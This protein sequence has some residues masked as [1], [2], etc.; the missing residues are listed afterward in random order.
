[1]SAVMQG[2]AN[3]EI[4][5]QQNTI[6]SQRAFNEQLFNQQY[7]Q[8]MVNRSE[9]SDMFRKLGERQ[10]LERKRDNATSSVM[11]ESVEAGI[12]RDNARGKQYAD[13]TAGIAA[14]AGIY[15]DGLLN[16]WQNY[17]NQYY[18]QLI[19]M[20]DKLAG[21]SANTANQWSKA[22]MG[23]YDI[24]GNFGGDAIDYWKNKG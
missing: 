20:S 22:G 6:D 16:N 10:D 7:Y 17:G 8:D 18:N 12:A 13:A 19:G 15:K 9:I 24:A 11:G 21:I 3:K 23:F 4:K 1:M 14:N 2:K 5:S